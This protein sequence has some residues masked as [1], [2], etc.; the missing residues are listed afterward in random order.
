M[1][2]AGSIKPR[3]S[4]TMPSMKLSDT[5]PFTRPA[6]PTMASR[7]MRSYPRWRPWRRPTL[8]HRSHYGGRGG[9][10]PSR[11]R[12]RA[13]CGLLVGHSAA[14][15]RSFGEWFSQYHPVLYR[16]S[17]CVIKSDGLRTNT[18]IKL[19]RWHTK[20]VT[21]RRPAKTQREL[22]RVSCYI[23]IPNNYGHKAEWKFPANAIAIRCRKLHR[24][25]DN[26]GR[27]SYLGQAQC[28]SWIQK[29]DRLRLRGRPVKISGRS[30]P[31][32]FFQT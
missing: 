27:H 31:L 17:S 9:C 5:T 26:E 13:R 32:R 25:V 22:Y 11:C 29:A 21:L 15:Y 19:T 20:L 14:P 30:L 18:D 12:R 16:S 10:C 28:R 6:A 24:E 2:I 7:P 23:F 3:L 1:F 8:P 4:T